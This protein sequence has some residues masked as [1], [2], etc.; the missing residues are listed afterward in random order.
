MQ[1]A[2]MGEHSDVELPVRPA[3]RS[4]CLHWPNPVLRIHRRRHCSRRHCYNQHIFICIYRPNH[5]HIC[6]HTYT[7]AYTDSTYGINTKN[8]RTNNQGLA[9]N[10]DNINNINSNISA[11]RKLLVMGA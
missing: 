2:F 8:N 6:P 1:A 4:Y 5:N 11:T 9:A 7:H 10:P 3:A